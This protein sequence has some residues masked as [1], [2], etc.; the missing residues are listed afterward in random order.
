MYKGDDRVKQVEAIEGWAGDAVHGSDLTM[1]RAIKDHGW[2]AK[3][4]VDNLSDWVLES[5][6]SEEDGLPD[7]W[8]DQD[9]ALLKDRIA[10]YGS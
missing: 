7:W 10:Q 3:Q 1:E 2:T 6:E 5:I 4:W 8:D 9:T